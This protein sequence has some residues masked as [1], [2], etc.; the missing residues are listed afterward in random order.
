LDITIKGGIAM[1]APTNFLTWN[2]NKINQKSDANYLIDTQRA[3]GAVSGIYPSILANKLFYQCSV[4]AT[5]LA[6]MMVNKGFE[7][8]DAVFADL[9]A[10]LSHILTDAQFGAGAGTVC[11][12]NDDRLNSAN[13]KMWFY[14]NVA[15]TGWT[16][17]TSVADAMIAVKGGTNA[18]NAAGG[19]QAGTWTQPGHLHAVADA[20]APLPA[21]IHEVVG[22]TNTN[23][24]NHTHD[25]PGST[26]YGTASGFNT[27]AH[28]M[29]QSST[30][31]ASHTHNMD[32]N[33]Q[34]TGSGTGTHNHGNTGANATPTTWRPLANVG[35]ICTKD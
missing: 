28:A 12:G 1:A 24:Q 7:M 8:Q 16:I 22:I 35:I 26:G 27:I 30:E 6:T 23:N 14:M 18:Y 33:S 19:S 29:G 25:V 3:G 11:Q 17:D 10:S 15:P 34:S 5:A 2:P 13:T 9:V 20:N 31:S 32:F 4:M 21:H